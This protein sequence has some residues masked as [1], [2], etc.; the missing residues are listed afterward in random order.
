MGTLVRAVIETRHTDQAY[1]AFQAGFARIRELDQR[2]SHYKPESELMRLCRAGEAKVSAD[3][4]R[5]LEQAQQIA[6]ETNGAF[7]VTIGDRTRRSTF[8]DIEMRG[9]SVRLLKP[10][11]KLDLG[12]IA[13]GYAGDEM[14]RVFRTHGCGRAMVAVSGDVVCGDGAWSVKLEASG[15]TLTL[16]QCAA[17]TSGDTVQRHIFDARSGRYVE[18]VWLVSVVARTGMLADALATALRVLGEQEGQKLAARHRAR[19][20][21]RRVS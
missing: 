18:G 8:R 10:E 1:Q 20:W 9:H 6:F 16:K 14:L 21:F 11:M 5:V 2:L 12:G 19:A 3:L 17:S 13:K 4:F 7:D 15:E